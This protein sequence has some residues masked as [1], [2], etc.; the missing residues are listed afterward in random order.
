MAHSAS[1]LTAVPFWPEQSLWIRSSLL[2]FTVLLKSKGSTVQQLLGCFLL[3]KH[4]CEHRRSFRTLTLDDIWDKHTVLT[5]W[6]F[7]PHNLMECRASPCC[8]YQA[9]FDSSGSDWGA[10]FILWSWNHAWIDWRLKK[11]ENK[12]TER[13]SRQTQD[14]E[15]CNRCQVWFPSRHV[16]KCCSKEH[17]SLYFWAFCLKHPGKLTHL[18]DKMDSNN[19]TSV[20]ENK[21]Y[22]WFLKKKKKKLNASLNRSETQYLPNSRMI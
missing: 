19:F 16:L 14:R 7:N 11:A 18:G 5:V 10:W 21:N 15:P 4:N 12:W 3:E 1:L 9:S 13:V 2:L 8:R 17:E 20:L 6:K 22:I